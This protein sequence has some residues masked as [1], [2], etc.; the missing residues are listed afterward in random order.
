MTSGSGRVRIEIHPGVL[1]RIL[2]G[3][4]ARAYRHRQA[5]Q[6]ATAWQ[7]NIHRVTGA[8]EASIHVVEEGGQ[9]LVV[10]DQAADP[11]SAWL[12]LEYGTSDTPAQHPG[13]RAIRG[14]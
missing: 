1:E 14:H 3:S 6:I 4:Q 7:G 9:T 5:E 2:R 13:R 8:T 10:A 11:D 12:Y